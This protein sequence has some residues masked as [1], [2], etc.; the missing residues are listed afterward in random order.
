VLD[1][2]TIGE[3]NMKRLYHPL[4]P[5]LHLRNRSNVYLKFTIQVDIC[6][7]HGNSNYYLEDER[8]FVNILEVLRRFFYELKHAGNTCNIQFANYPKSAG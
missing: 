7:S 6:P 5:L 2:F 4:E 3:I 1:D 8:R